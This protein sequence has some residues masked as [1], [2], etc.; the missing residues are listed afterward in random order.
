MQGSIQAVLEA[1]PR[2][3]RARGFVGRGRLKSVAFLPH[4][5]IVCGADAT[6]TDRQ[7]QKKSPQGGGYGGIG[8]KIFPLWEGYGS[9][10]KKNWRS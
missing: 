8:T 7:Q 1:F 4:P 2:T 5:W 3:S 9:I 10:G 6:S